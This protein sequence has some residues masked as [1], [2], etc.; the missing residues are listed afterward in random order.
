MVNASW[1]VLNFRMN[2]IRDLMDK[3]FEPWVIAPEDDYAVRFVEMGIA[4]QPIKYLTRRGTN[5]ILDIML[6]FELYHIFQRLK[7][8]VVLLYTIKPNIYGSL[9]AR[10]SG[11]KSMATVTGL[12]YSFLTRKYTGL[13][14]K[15]MYKFAFSLTNKIIFHNQDDQQLFIKNNW[16]PEK[17]STVIA[18]S[19][20][21]MDKYAPMSHGSPDKRNLR[22]LYIGRILYDKGIREL[23]EA[24]QML[25]EEKNDVELILLGKIDSKNPSAFDKTELKNW[26]RKFDN[27]EHIDGTDDVRPYLADADIVVLPSYRE[28]LPKTILEA[29]SME[30]P[31]IVT[32]VPG[33]R[34]TITKKEPV[35][36]YF[37]AVKN[38]ISIYE[39]MLKMSKLTNEERILMG[40]S[41][42]S[43]VRE[44]FDVKI[45][46]R[47][48]IKL[49]NDLIG[50][51][52]NK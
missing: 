23:L 14:V 43:Y 28:G 6:T 39:Q 40:R 32:D 29:M 3:G 21:D 48:Y 45:I 11:I 30:K 10:L 26:L 15:N 49:V 31:I 9:A 33:C 12:G 44:K 27:A 13:L 50:K 36:G 51:R 38:S 4:Y 20:V 19:G 52:R 25:C 42:R 22:F 8:E 24:F 1:N 2:L 46:N 37:C 41:G 16:V 17:R 18:G 7:P 47:T 35:N 34:D 5:P